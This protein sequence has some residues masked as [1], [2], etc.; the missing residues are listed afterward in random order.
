ML[1]FHW[2]EREKSL[3]IQEL[4]DLSN[5]L[6][7]LG[8]KSVL[9]VTNSKQSDNWIKAANAINPNHNLKYLI[10]LR[11]YMIT[12]SLCAMMIKGFNEISP[13]RI[14]LNIVSGEI[15]K[16]EGSPE[17]ITDID[18]DINKKYERL[19][20]IETFLKNLYSII[21]ENDR[22]EILVG[23]G[24]KEVIEFSKKYTDI[25]LCMY[26]DFQK[27]DLSA[28]KRKMVSVQMVLRDTE[29][30]ANKF[31]FKFKG[32]RQEKNTIY[33][34]KESVIKKIISLEDEGVTDLLISV[35]PEDPLSSRVLTIINDL[36]HN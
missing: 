25:S 35:I 34:T 19:V 15:S 23:S 13:N 8:Y 2:M 17:K 14:G 11:P 9:L 21:S 7:M 26:D 1:N 20:Y 27:N 29:Y 33:G 30:E 5:T 32:T 3:S 36:P 10:A 18:V 4:K 16:A 22:P 31:M 28:F 24:N 6:E 12:A